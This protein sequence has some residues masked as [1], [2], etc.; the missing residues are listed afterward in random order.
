[1][2]RRLAG[3]RA[4]KFTKRARRALSLA[5]Q[6]AQRLRHNYIGSEHLLL[7]LAAD[8]GGIAA[9]VLQRLGADLDRLRSAVTWIVPAG[10]EAP[11]GPIGLTEEAKAAIEQ[12]LVQAN[13]MKQRYLGTEHVLLG[14]MRQTDGK[15]AQVLRDLNVDEAQVRTIV[16]ELLEAH[17]ENVEPE[18]SRGNVVMCRLTDAD[19]DALDTLVEAGV[20]TTRS[21]S[22]AWLIQAGVKA[23]ADLFAAIRDKVDQIREM[24]QSARMLADQVLGNPER[25]LNE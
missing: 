13:Q 15:G 7:G 10:A 23:N 1:M 19:L 12:A 22:A 17:G 5:Q 4:D 16:A 2:L 9:R 8:E 6:E 18:P 21:D 25:P 14:I 24:R 3:D 20:R 11:D